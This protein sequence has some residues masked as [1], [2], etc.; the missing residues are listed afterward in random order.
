MNT[1]TVSIAFPDL[2]H[3]NANTQ[4]ESLLSELKQDAK[5]KG[6]L[7]LDETGVKRI[8]REGQ[9]FGVTLI[10]VLGTPAVIILAKAVERSVER[11][12]TTSIAING[13]RIDNVRSQDVAAIAK[14][15]EGN[16]GSTRK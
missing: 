14:A 10:A 4:A 1:T 5:L 15:L 6:L 7:D 9:D 12:G 3:P 2:N 8:D 16:A 11:T 13:V